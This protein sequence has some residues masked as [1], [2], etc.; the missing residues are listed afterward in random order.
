MAHTKPTQ[1]AGQRG[2]LAKG[3]NPGTSEAPCSE[4]SEEA[5]GWGGG[6]EGKGTT[7][8]GRRWDTGPICAHTKEAAEVT[9]DRMHVQ[10]A[11]EADGTPQSSRRH[12]RLGLRGRHRTR[13]QGREVR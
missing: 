5:A 6:G 12:P 13:G 10:W 7:T 4:Q 11:T 2:V 1:H 9:V 8:K 3:L